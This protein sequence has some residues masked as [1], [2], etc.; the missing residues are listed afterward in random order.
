[1]ILF[2]CGKCMGWATPEAEKQVTC[3]GRCLKVPRDR[4]PVVSAT[5]KRVREH[6][7][8]AGGR[9]QTHYNYF[10]VDRMSGPTWELNADIKP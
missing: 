6:L 8:A 3:C 2:V 1:M 10:S 7:Q 4:S 5:D 9:V